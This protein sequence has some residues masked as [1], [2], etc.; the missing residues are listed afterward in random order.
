MIPYGNKFSSFDFHLNPDI[1]TYPIIKNDILRKTGF[2]MY[3]QMHVF[4]SS[5][6]QSFLEGIDWHWQMGTLLDTRY[7]RKSPSL[8]RIIQSHA[9]CSVFHA[10]W[11]PFKKTI[12]PKYP[13]NGRLSSPRGYYYGCILMKLCETSLLG[14]FII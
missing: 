6:L 11:K 9:S 3:S 5:M 14:Y 13:K 7:S 4:H 1:C 8:M 10:I 2:Q 12:Y